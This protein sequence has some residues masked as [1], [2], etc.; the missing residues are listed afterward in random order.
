[1]N[2]KI[3]LFSLLVFLNSF[4]FAQELFPI[5][6]IK[7]PRVGIE[8][9]TV[10]IEGPTVGIEGPTAKPSAPS[11]FNTC[12]KS[13]LY[14]GTIVLP[15]NI[16]WYWQSSA[17]G[18]STSSPVSQNKELTYSGT[19]YVRSLNKSSVI[20]SSA[21]SISVTVK[22]NPFR[23]SV[24][25]Q[26]V[27]CSS[28]TLT[29][30]SQPS[31]ITW[32]WQGTNSKGKSNSNSSSTYTVNS[33]GTYYLRARNNST[34]C[35]SLVRSVNV[36][37]NPGPSNPSTPTV[38]VGCESSTVTRGTPPSGITWYWQ[39]S[40]GGISTSNSNKTYTVNST[41]TVYLRARNNST[42][43]WSGSTSKYVRINTPPSQ[44]NA[45]SVSNTCG[46]SV[47]SYGEVLLPIYTKW[48]WQSSAGGTS[49][50]SP[51][52]QNKELT[53]SGTVY[54]RS[55]NSFTGCWSSARSISVTV[56]QNPF[57]PSVPS[58][59]VGC[60]SATLTKGSQPSGITW[61]WQGTN[62]KGK[63]NSNSSSTY[64]VNSNGTYYLRARNNST[65]CWSLVR[66]VNVTLNP[67]PSNPST[68]TV[69]VGC[70]S[71]TM[72]R[73]TPP[74]GITWYWQT[75]SGGISTSNSNKTYTV[76]STRTVYLRARNNST[77]CWSGS[78]SKYVRID[79]PP[80][81]PNAPSVS[82]T[83][84]KSVL[85][86]G[87]MLL[88]TGTKW[89]WQSS[90][91]G[92]ST[93]SP[94]SQN[95]E[96]TSSGTVY[97]RSLNSFTGCWSSARSISVT[98]KQNPFIPS[99]PSQSVDCSSATLTKGSQPSGITWYWQGTNS[100][101]KSNSNSSST[102]TVNS[103]GTYYLRARN[104]STGCWSL[105]RSV[106][107]T[108]N[109]GPSNPSTPTVSVGCESSTVTRGT[110][111]SGI[112]WYW[113][114]S[115][116]G[117]STSNS[118]KT[119]TVNSTRTVYLRARSNSTG[120]WS[121]ST[122]LNVTLMDPPIWYLDSD[123]DGY[124]DGYE[125]EFWPFI[126]GTQNRLPRMVKSCNPHYELDS[127]GDTIHYV[128]NKIDCF[129]NDPNRYDVRFYID[130]DK[131]GYG[132]IN[133]VGLQPVYESCRGAL[134]L[135]IPL[136][137]SRCNSDANDHDA[138]I[139]PNM[140]WFIDTDNDGFGVDGMN[141]FTGNYPPND[142]SEYVRNDLDLC[143]D[144]Y[145]K[146]SGCKNLNLNLSN[147][148]YIL[149]RTL[150]TPISKSNY[151]IDA[152]NIESIDVVSY[153]DGLGRT[154]QIN[155]AHA[156]SSFGD[157]VSIYQ[158]DIAGRQSYHYLPYT[159]NLD[160]AYD[161]QAAVNQKNYYKSNY[162]NDSIAFSY[163]NYSDGPL[164]RILSKSAP[165]NDWSYV[166]S[167]QN[168]EYSMN[169][170]Q[171]VYYFPNTS[172]VAL[173]TLQYYS[174]NE[175]N[176][177]TTYDEDS[178]QAIEYTNTLGQTILKKSQAGTVWS[179]T[180]YIYDVYGN[181]TTVLPPEASSRLDT[182]FFPVAIA[183]R[184]TFLHTWAF[185]YDYDGRNRMIMKKVPGA[186]PVYM[187]YDQWDRLVLTQDGVHR[188]SGQWLYTKYDAF[189]RP[190]MNGLYS[191]NR[192]VDV[193]I[194]E[195]KSS[196]NRYESINASEAYQ[197]SNKSFP[198][199]NLDKVLTVT[200]FDDYSFMNHDEWNSL[201]MTFADPLTPDV[202]SQGRAV[203]GQVTGRMTRTDDG[204]YIRSVS[205]YDDKY[206]LIQTHTTNHLG[207]VDVV[208]NY[209]DF[210]GQLLKSIGTHNSPYG[211]QS[212]KRTYRYD[213]A[214]RLLETWHQVNE[215]EPILL[216]KS[217][218][219]ELGELIEKALHAK[220]ADPN[221]F[222]QSI[223]YDYNIR[224]WLKSINEPGL[225]G[226][227]EIPDPTVLFH[228]ELIYN[229]TLNGLPNNN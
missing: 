16:Q 62:S 47:L 84:G 12:G 17:G 159:Q 186:E 103:N 122:S 4:V 101:G 124:G 70:E 134:Q 89:Y 207:G 177:L 190:V 85:S 82:N 29:K 146:F 86:Y 200:Y 213:H 72:T 116:G 21:R 147:E 83:C 208:T 129:T 209:Y 160:G 23:P 215:D 108:L 164:D 33:N 98:V 188:K 193:I 181:L 74:S 28:A 140:K 195:V 162:D 196:V 2:S 192:S 99:V 198:T 11:V 163:T 227:P 120:C 125:D 60:S 194:D 79:T 80:S 77:G 225:Q 119:Y 221:T 179:E 8:G 127:T 96:L 118:N 130:R 115:S 132:D 226:V 24:P 153:V 1:M 35:W 95:K 54:V 3:R 138:S 5:G 137:Y 204:S 61:Y 107:V 158:Y 87:E 214:G 59:S 104:N 123:G 197:Y 165:G 150:T 171:E 100:K 156:S 112:T 88:L 206:R 97:V 183:D 143:P 53:S 40:S 201:G 30:G 92:T 113:Q 42:G 45:P 176:K 217:N 229:G 169:D 20:W 48:Y 63:S 184:E 170:E 173:A 9:P 50:S 58:Q 110:P 78:T 191:D 148:N 6:G 114:T 94:V 68:P 167:R 145:G 149:S 39:T 121:G 105:V 49:T 65:G 224:G 66:S 175:L 126:V 44:P 22:Q 161:L 7:G 90:A 202:L 91:G 136:G 199:F 19:V 106:N 187:V 142:G 223:D 203:Q 154:I 38:S 75:S 174:K 172:R 76:N 27:G 46:K 36:T 141:T 139:N 15:A 56:K 189:N 205:Y 182:E 25:S 67:G 31:G 64:T 55:L 216:A 117:I 43:C 26:S 102:Y 111:P 131:D 168:L 144:V 228:M 180:Y 14:Y 219:N 133:D 32:Y 210:I 155:Q 220:E 13:I 152:A 81:Q 128:N 218:Y 71:S 178:I 52:S 211:S 73:G 18:T 109:P 166:N 185:I 151:T 157:I 51:V 69:S 10:G 41:R 57:R 93:S 37:L 222:K 135:E 34:G 212:I